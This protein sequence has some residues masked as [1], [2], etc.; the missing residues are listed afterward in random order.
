[1]FCESLIIHF[2]GWDEVIDVDGLQGL[3]G[4]DEDS[5]VRHDSTIYEGSSVDGGEG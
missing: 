2:V 5:L 1:M 3:E 4:D